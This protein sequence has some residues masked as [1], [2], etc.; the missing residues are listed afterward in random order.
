MLRRFFKLGWTPWTRGMVGWGAL[1]GWLQEE[2]NP[3]VNITA[4]SE[5]GWVRL[6]G[7]MRRR[8]FGERVVRA[9]TGYFV[10]YGYSHLGS[11]VHTA[12]FSLTVN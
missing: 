5:R 10:G 4:G 8:E 1:L 11:L 6:A 3:A 12:T 2:R 7:R 9:P